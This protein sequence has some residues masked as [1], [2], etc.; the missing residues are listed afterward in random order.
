MTNFGF[1]CPVHAC[2]LQI[3]YVEV[4][5]ANQAQFQ[6]GISLRESGQGVSNRGQILR[7]PL[8]SDPSQYDLFVRCFFS[9]DITRGINRSRDLRDMRTITGCKFSGVGIFYNGA[10]CGLQH[11]GYAHCTP[12]GSQPVDPSRVG[13][14]ECKDSVVKIEKYFVP[15]SAQ[16]ARYGK[17]K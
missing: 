10:V 4:A 12:P 13:V 5:R 6:I 7:C 9:G 15:V 16:Q 2:N 1:Q 11:R 14:F 8:A 17:G 3:G